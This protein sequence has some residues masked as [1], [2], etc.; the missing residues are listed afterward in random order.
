[1]TRR[2]R[3]WRATTGPA[4]LIAAVVLAPPATS[5]AATGDWRPVKGAERGLLTDGDRYVVSES[6]GRVVRVNDTVTDRRRRLTTPPCDDGRSRL[7][8]LGSGMLVWEC[9]GFIGTS[10][11]TLVVDDLASGRRF[12]PPGL[13]QFQALE[14]DSS[15][16]S[17]FHVDLAGEHWIY[18]TRSGYHYADDVLVALDG[19]QVVHQPAQRADV[20]IDPDRARGTRRLCA[21]IRRPAGSPELGELPYGV[22]DYH[23]PY[24]FAGVGRLRACSG[25]PD[26]P[27]GRVAVALSDSALSWASGSLLAIRSTTSGRTTRRRAP[28]TVR[29]IALTRRFVYVTTPSAT[30]RS[31]ISRRS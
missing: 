26:P 23:R 12:V 29:K 27:R 13:A 14:Q 21:G 28:G 1:V 7:S 4:L 15:D 10:R 30:Y 16:G 11:H 9:G 8:A 6:R 19:P 31:R 17:V 24:A 20:A 25:A 18:L 5:A 22:V 3:R 2:S